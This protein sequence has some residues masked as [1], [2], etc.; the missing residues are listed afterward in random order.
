LADVTMTRDEIASV[1][2][3][4][5][6]LDVS[7]RERRLL[8]EVVRLAGDAAAPRTT[9]ASPDVVDVGSF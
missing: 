3:K 2:A 4:L 9:G 7:D 6:D 5:D 1:V 8:R